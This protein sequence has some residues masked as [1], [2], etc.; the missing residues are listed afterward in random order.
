MLLREIIRNITNQCTQKDKLES[1][2]VN[3][4]TDNEQQTTNNFFM[5]VLITGASRGIGFELGK[6]FSS[7]GATTLFLL[8]RNKEKISQLKSECEKINPE[9]KIVLLPF[10]LEEEGSFDPRAA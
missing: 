5:N 8:S 4:A 1:Y 9:I 7:H 6:Y 10:S 3:P 2:L